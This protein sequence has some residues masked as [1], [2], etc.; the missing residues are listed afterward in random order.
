MQ[1]C[2]AAGATTSRCVESKRAS[3]EAAT[4]TCPGSPPA[5][6][7]QHTGQQ[8]S[9]GSCMLCMSFYSWIRITLTAEWHQTTDADVAV[10]AAVS[11]LLLQPCQAA[12]GMTLSMCVVMLGSRL[13]ALHLLAEQL[14]ADTGSLL[15][16]YLRAIFAVTDCQGQCWSV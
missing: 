1:V 6:F 7:V 14:P 12:L 11:S 9:C 5:V 10:S 16:E 8:I 13:S 15:T 3:G 2:Q 4:Y